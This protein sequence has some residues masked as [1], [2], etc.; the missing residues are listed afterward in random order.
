MACRAVQQKSSPAF[1]PEEDFAI[2]L[3]PIYGVG[4][5]V[6]VVVVVVLSAGLVVAMGLDSAGLVVT[7]VL[8]VL[9][10][11]EVAGDAEGF[12]M[13]VLFSVV[14]AGDAAGAAVSVFCSQ[15]ARSAALA[16]MQ[17]YFFIGLWML[18]H[19]GLTIDS[20]Q[21]NFSALLY[22]FFGWDK[23]PSG[24]NNR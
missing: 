7:V 13:V 17:I 19:V 14:S 2:E 1:L 4:D 22:L 24:R 3:R 15:A 21:A 11:V 16:R 9:V 18:A 10:S 6:V 23:A 20:E 8:V 5:V 12:T